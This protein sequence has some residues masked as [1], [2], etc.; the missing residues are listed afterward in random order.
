MHILSVKITFL[1][2]LLGLSRGEQPPLFPHSFTLRQFKTLLKL[3]N[4]TFC[5]FL[6]EAP[7]AAVN[8]L[9]SGGLSSVAPVLDVFL[10]PTTQ[11]MKFVAVSSKLLKNLFSSSWSQRTS[12]GNGKAGLPL[13]MLHT[14]S[15]ADTIQF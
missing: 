14:F 1:L 13:Q 10:K 15:A 2:S 8:T 5:D 6:V 12:H 3:I 4:S 11:I 7:A 9:S